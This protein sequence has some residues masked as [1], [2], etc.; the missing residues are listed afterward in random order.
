MAKRP[1]KRAADPAGTIEGLLSGGGGKPVLSRPAR[2][3]RR[4]FTPDEHIAWVQA[5]CY[6]ETK[7]GWEPLVYARWQREAI[8]ELLAVTPEGLLRARTII[9]C[10]PRR[11]EKTGITAMYDVHRAM[12]Y[13]NQVIVIQANSADQVDDTVMKC[14]KD[15]IEASPELAKLVKLGDIEFA[16]GLVVF[17]RT[18]SVIKAQPAEERST[19]GQKISVYHNTELC[20]ASSDAL[21]QVGA[22]STGDS[23]CGLSIIDSNMGDRA[24]AVHRLVDL[25]EQAR[26]ERIRAAEERRPVN[27]A[28]G[29]PAIA[30]VWIHFEDLD[31]CLKRGCG[32]GLE[33][34]VEPVHPWLTADWIR[35]RFAQMTR[36][37]FL[38]NHC[39]QPSGAGEV[40]WSDE[41]IA[42]LFRPGLP[43]IVRREALATVLSGCDGQ[44]AVGVG[45]DRASAFSKLPDR[46][47]M[48]A[49][50]R[51]HVPALVGQ[52]MPVYD[53]R[54]REV[55]QEAGD[56]NVYVLLGAWDFM[57]I[58]A[59]PLQ[60]RLDAIDRTWGIGA[61][62]MEAYQ[63]SDLVEWSK[64]RP[65]GDKIELRHMTGHAKRQLVAFA[66]QLIVTR[67]MLISPEYAVL[68]AEFVNYR[69]EASGG[70]PSYGGPRKIMDLD[71]P[72]SDGPAIRRT[73]WIK[74]DYLEAFFWALEAAR[75]A[76]ARGR[77]V[78]IDKPFGL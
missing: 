58:L 68:R 78:V 62:R 61:G 43:A 66:H 64:T 21:Y 54:G 50:G 36:S 44:L 23:W 28:I 14:I 63:A 17:N 27:P 75:D 25:A 56:G 20:K 11:C 31:D 60:Q 13:D 1:K 73:T 70:Q 46:T 6:R 32:E 41:Q 45:L 37:E 72:R 47:V 48:A 40:L 51:L 39:N 74:D 33:A 29:D 30:A 26:A 12:A 77:A 53:E 52:P 9:P 67:R 57:Y 8:R 42:P 3:A 18:G 15:T 19:Y 65:Y 38:R 22:S 4:H 76:T 35:S 69:E 55:G 49:V 7:A 2:A 5:N 16:A 34:G 71:F 59:A 24:N 10:F